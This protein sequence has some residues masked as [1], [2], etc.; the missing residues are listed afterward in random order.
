[1]INIQ[2]E[3]QKIHNQYGM[4]E[5]ANYKIQLLTEQYAK[6]Y[7]ESKV[8]KLNLPAVSGC[9]LTTRE[10]SDKFTEEWAQKRIY[11]YERCSE[12]KILAWGYRQG[13]EE[14]REDLLNNR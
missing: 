1:M 13:Y 12:S 5:M 2:N 8:K 6:E 11:E 4:N 10:V 9:L 3:V 7:H 14:A